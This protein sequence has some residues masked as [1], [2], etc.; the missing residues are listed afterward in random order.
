MH[1]SAT[2]IRKGSVVLF[3]GALCLVTEY[4]HHTPGNLRAVIHSKLKNLKT[5]GTYNQRFSS[6][7]RLEIAHLDPREVEYLY[8]E[9]DRYVFMDTASFEQ[10]SLSKED[11]GDAMNYVKL[12]DKVQVAFHDDKPITVTLPSS[13][14]LTVTETDPGAKGNSV[15]NVYKPAKLETGL[16]IKVPLFIENGAKIKVDTRTGE[17]LDRVN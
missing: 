13:V 15:T 6:S 2:E 11:V 14:V 7:D 4:N 17:Y 10:V 1:L 9:G 3:E 16:S 8:P 5:G 12:N